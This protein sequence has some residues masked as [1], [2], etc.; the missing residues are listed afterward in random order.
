LHNSS[1]RDPVAIFTLVLLLSAVGFSVWLN[2]IAFGQVI[3]VVLMDATREIFIGLLRRP[4]QLSDR[5]DLLS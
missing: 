3:A 2:A 5:L 4:S 1:H